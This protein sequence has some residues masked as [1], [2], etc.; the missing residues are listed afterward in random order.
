MVDMVRKHCVEGTGNYRTADACVERT[1]KMLGE[2][3][4][5]K[6]NFVSLDINCYLH[7]ERPNWYL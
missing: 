3:R 1:K 2:L 5:I 6:R 7:Y 4:D